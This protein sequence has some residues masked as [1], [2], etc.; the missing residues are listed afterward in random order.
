VAAAIKVGDIDGDGDLDVVVANHVT[1]SRQTVG[2][3]SIY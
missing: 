1:D 3:F 2:N